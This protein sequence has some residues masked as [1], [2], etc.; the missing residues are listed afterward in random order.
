MILTEK[1]Y[2][3]MASRITEGEGCID[4]ERH[5]ELLVFDYNLI[6]E[7]YN[8]RETNAIIV[9][10]VE[11]YIENICCVNEFGDDIPHNFDENRLIDM[12]YKDYRIN[13]VV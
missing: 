10:D 3:E 13:V 2:I 12:V 8:E 4:I 1:D 7:S 5:G 6:V 11:L 9:T